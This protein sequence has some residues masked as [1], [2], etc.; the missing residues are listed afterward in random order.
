MIVHSVLCVV[1]SESNFHENIQADLVENSYEFLG[2]S[3]KLKVYIQGKGKYLVPFK[4][5]AKLDPLMQGHIMLIVKREVAD[6]CCGKN[7][8]K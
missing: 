5:L 8:L 1:R 3:N 7:I 6:H 2:R 4:L